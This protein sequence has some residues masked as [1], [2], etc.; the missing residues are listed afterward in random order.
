MSKIVKFSLS[1]ESY[2]LL[3]GRAEEKRLS[4]QDYIRMELF[5]DAVKL[6]PLDAIKEALKKYNA[7]ESFT[8]PEILGDRWDLPNGE[9]GQFGKKFFQLVESEYSSELEFAGLNRNK[10]AVYRRK[11]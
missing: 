8:V 6:T 11:G 3:C 9:A 10:R 2:E 5:P 1:D 7:G 4:L